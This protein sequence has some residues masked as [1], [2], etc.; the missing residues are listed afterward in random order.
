[1]SS[2]ALT[3]AKAWGGGQGPDQGGLVVSLKAPHHL[4]EGLPVDPVGRPC[5]ELPGPHVEEGLLKEID[6]HQAPPQ[7]PREG[8]PAL[9]R[10]R[11][12]EGLVHAAGLI[13]ADHLE[14]L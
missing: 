12:I 8:R 7:A 1:M 14:L 10:A 2:L 3:A 6:G 5:R 13:D 9:G 11:P 4:V